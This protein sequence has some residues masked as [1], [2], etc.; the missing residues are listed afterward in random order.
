MI[1]HDRL[2]K[3]LITTFFWEFVELFLPDLARYLDNNSIVFLDKEIFTDVT[4][5]ERHEVDILA[6]GKFRGSD[7]CF[8][9]HCETQAQDPTRMPQ[10]MFDYFGRLHAKFRLPVYPIVVLAHDS[11]ASEP[12]CYEVKFP[13]LEVLRLTS[14]S[15]TCGGSTGAT[16]CCNRTRS[17]PH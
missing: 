7:S 14:G 8:L 4:S 15:F 1:D 6:K 10:R 17:R 13:D 16:L 5:G 11:P 9:V 3:E 2:F 12:D